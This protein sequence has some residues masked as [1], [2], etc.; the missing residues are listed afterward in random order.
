M[1]VIESREILSKIDQ[2]GEGLDEGRMRE[3]EALRRTP[4]FLAA[5]Q[6]GQWFLPLSDLV[7]L[8]NFLWNLLDNGGKRMGEA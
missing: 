2:P 1:E 7:L 8:L 6:E 4:E 5:Y 3:R